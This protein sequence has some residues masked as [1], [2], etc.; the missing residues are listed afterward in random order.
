MHGA[1]MEAIPKRYAEELHKQGLKPYS[2][3]IKHES[4][5]RVIWVVNALDN[6]AAELLIPNVSKAL[7]K[8]LYLQKKDCDIVCLEQSVE[9]VAIKSLF[10]DSYV[11]LDY[12]RIHNLTFVT[13]LGIKIKGR[14]E[15]YPDL[16]Y[17]FRN[18]MQRFD[19]I[20]D[21]YKIYDKD[22]L[23][24]LVDH[25]HIIDYKLRTTR[26]H[27]EGTKIPAC[28]G[29]MVVKVDGSEVMNNL[30]HLLF[31]FASYSGIG[32]KTTLG[33]GGTIFGL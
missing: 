8:G 15:V 5:G 18:L 26:Y 33:M 11:T 6:Q 24:H 4:N 1:I 32:I 22:A 29:R 30:V 3:H 25:C 12:G 20:T 17:I 2:Q 13:P 23:N 9:E 27:L 21:E 28:L 19:M 7:N 14:Y 10:E 31:T 16:R